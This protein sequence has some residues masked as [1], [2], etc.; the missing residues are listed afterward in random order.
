MEFFLGLVCAVAATMS[1]LI[2]LLGSQLA[3]VFATV[4]AIVVLALGGFFGNGK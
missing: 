1:E 4:V 3:A 2:T